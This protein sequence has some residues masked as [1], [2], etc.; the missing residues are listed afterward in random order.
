MLIEQLNSALIV[1]DDPI[2]CETARIYFHK[3]GTPSISV[4]YNG[5]QALDIIEQSDGRIDFIL[6]DL[7]MPEMDGIQFLRRM[8]LRAYPGTIAILS[9]ESAGVMSLAMDLARKHGLN[10]V[11]PVAKPLK[12]G[13]LDGLFTAPDKTNP[14]ANA[15]KNFTPT[16]SDLD[17]ALA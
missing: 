13:I 7:S 4:A 8:H 2:A 9:G 1:D 12:V 6:L 17:A 5:K 14:A 10:V 3:R 11:G 16:S 15:S